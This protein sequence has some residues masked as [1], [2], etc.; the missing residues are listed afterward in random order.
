MLSSTP[1]HL[2]QRC[3]SQYVASLQQ[4]AL[5]LSIKLGRALKNCQ[6]MHICFPTDQGAIGAAF[7]AWCHCLQDHLTGKQYM[8]WKAIRDKLTEMQERQ[9]SQRLPPPPGRPEEARP[10]Q[11]RERDR[12]CAPCLLICCNTAHMHCSNC[13]ASDASF[14]CF[15]LWHSG[16]HIHCLNCAQPNCWH[17]VGVA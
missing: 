16:P 10:A 5:S 8:G 4:M 14:L 13:S 11:H 2:L 9:S 12:Y 17:L 1:T 15:F 6:N 3:M 7:G